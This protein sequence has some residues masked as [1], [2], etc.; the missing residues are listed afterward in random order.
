MTDR[1]E[2]QE[3]QAQFHYIPDGWMG[4]QAAKASERAKYQGLFCRCITLLRAYLTQG[5]HGTLSVIRELE[6]AAF[7]PPEVN[8]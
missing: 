8:L 6:N 2:F 3:W 1:E 5:E 7:P 4:W